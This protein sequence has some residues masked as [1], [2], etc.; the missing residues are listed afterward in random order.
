M[1]TAITIDALKVLDAIDRNGSFAGA[2]NE[3]FRVPSA[4]S[5]TVQKLEEDLNVALFDRS[6]HRAALT[7]AGLYLLKEGRTLLDAAANLAHSTRQV[8]QGW[9]TRLRIGFNSLLPAECLFPAIKEFCALGIPV[10]VQITE[11]VFAGAWDALQGRR[12]DL[13]VGADDI[14]KPTGNFTS[15]MLGRMSFVFAVA[16]DHPLAQAPEPLSEDDICRF[17]AAVAADTSRSLPAGHA[18]IFHRQRTL[19]GANIDHKIAIQKAGLGVGW[20][21]KPRVKGLLASGQLIEK[22]VCEPRQAVA[23][24]A[25]R[26]ADD[27]GKALMWFWQRLT[28]DS[29]LT[30]WLD[31]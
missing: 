4:I 7:P 5:Y 18:G 11:E 12:A 14:S 1:Q 15:H 8:A 9:E 23:L 30:E 13:I 25:A 21:P 19:T 26:H 16:P 3:L 29:A 10:D 27:K 24:Q 31:A 17:P 28:S 20:L 2:A 6:G 22:Q